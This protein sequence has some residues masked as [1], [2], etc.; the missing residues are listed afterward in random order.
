MMRSI[1]CGASCVCSVAKTRCP[2]S[3]AVIAVPI[4]S[5]SRIS[6]TRM[7]SGA[8]RK[9]CFKAWPV[10]ADLPLVDDARLV[11]MEELDRVLDRHDVSG[12]L[13]VHDVDHRG[14]RRG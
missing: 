5:R 2:V 6:P 11:L 9:P 3:A 7:T 10:G 4:V 12:T 14:E 8:W 13:G 1:V